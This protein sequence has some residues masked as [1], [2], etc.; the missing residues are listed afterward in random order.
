MLH[1]ARLCG[2]LGLQCQGAIVRSQTRG[3]M[4]AMGRGVLG[5]LDQDSNPPI[6]GN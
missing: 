4:G 5:V 3:A 6:L 2:A 1:F